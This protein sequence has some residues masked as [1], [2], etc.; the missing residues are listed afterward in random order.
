MSRL[1]FKLRSYNPN[2]HNQP[3]RNSAH[4][5]YIAT[6]K[7][8][9]LN[10]GMGHG[11]FGKFDGME[12]MSD[13][14]DIKGAASYVKEKSFKKTN[15]YRA[16]ISFTEE[17]ATM[18]GLDKCE[19]WEKLV[20]SK[21]TY[22]ASEIGIKAQNLEW[23]SAVHMEQG[24]P[25]LHV[26]FWDKDQKVK[27]YFIEKEISNNIR[28]KLIKD[29]FSEQLQELYSENEDIKKNTG[30]SFFSDFSDLVDNMSDKDFVRIKRKFAVND[31]NIFDKKLMYNKFSDK[32]TADIADDLFKLAKN[33]PKKGRLS[34]AY[35]PSD[36]KKEI[37]ALVNKIIHGNKDLK[38]S[39]YKY[40]SNSADIV[41]F[42][43]DSAE[44]KSEAA[45]KAYDDMIKRLG[46][47]VLDVVKEINSRENE[48]LKQEYKRDMVLSLL[49]E[50]FFVLGQYENQTDAKLHTLKNG[51]LSK[52]AKID[53]AKQMES[54][55]IDW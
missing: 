13:I 26:V 36:T 31:K 3:H 16:I 19:E 25:H 17:D 32:F 29:I 18:L 37:D 51:E 15:M 41:L 34:Y 9:A 4:I 24:H 43:T 55:G 22:I 23:C 21:I 14:T 50:M 8:V 39:A 10:E 42:Y 7:G 20:N 45:Q 49:T 27:D 35:M 5:M 38:R 46:N 47:K 2:R 28:K 33:V 30:K 12:N 6:R 53:L 1:M 54:K 44:V 11:L 40:F 48:L 52:Q